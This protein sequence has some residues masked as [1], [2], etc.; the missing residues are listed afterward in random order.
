MTVP[1]TPNLVI[2]V[3]LNAQAVVP[4]K[5][6]TSAH[7]VKHSVHVRISSGWWQSFDEID[8]DCPEWAFRKRYGSMRGDGVPVYLRRLADCTL[9]CAFRG[10]PPNSRPHHPLNQL[11]HCRVHTRV[12]EAMKILEN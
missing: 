9:P 1:V 10:T 3:V 4:G 2:Q 6:I 7:L 12:I 5:G 8:M 11:V